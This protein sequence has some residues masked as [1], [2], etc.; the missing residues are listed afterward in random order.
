ME[1]NFTIILL[2][3]TAFAIFMTIFFI[4]RSMNLFGDK[5]NSASGSKEIARL[6]EENVKLKDQIT[7]YQMHKDRIE[8]K[9][10]E[11]EKTV[12]S[13]EE[14]R[15]NLEQTKLRLE[16]LN[17][18]KDELFTS[19]VHDIKNPVS[20]IRN[21]VQ[22]LK[23]YDLTAKEQ[24]DIMQSLLSTSSRIFK[25]V[26]EVSRVI[27]N[28][29]DINKLHPE[30]GQINDVV[31]NIYG[32]YEPLAHAKNIVF[33]KRLDR[34]LPLIMFDQ[35]KIGQV[36]D[37]LVNNAVK[38]SPRETEITVST[39][40]DEDNIVCEIKDTGYGLSQEEIIKAFEK[41]VV[42]SNKPTNNESSS[43][44]GL[45]IVKKIIEQHSGRV[46]VKSKLGSGST[47]AFKL[48]IKKEKIT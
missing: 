45:W 14:K 31:E 33:K 32:N 13:L 11:L 10:S 28:D 38:F 25:L 48:P 4:V 35:V 43:G 40:Q 44:I 23:S 2:G 19:V 5:M 1:I 6:R 15:F 16:E 47:F 46:W 42:L 8:Y 26:E 37:N 41:G 18:Q 7:F 3:I 17:I 20:T 12:K 9:I 22:L 36:I 24:S 21:F 34:N 27:S 29:R 39:F 30:L